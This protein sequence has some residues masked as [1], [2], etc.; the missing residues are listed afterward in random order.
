MQKRLKTSFTTFVLGLAT[1]PALVAQNRNSSFAEFKRQMMPKVGK[2]ITVVGSLASGKLGWV[3]T[4][5]KHGVYIYAVN[6]SDQ[7][8][9]ND[10]SRYLG[11]RV[12]VTGTLRYNPGSGSARDDVASVP[13]HFYFD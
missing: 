4:F 11:G 2:K 1:C 8:R 6:D 9:M 13:E 7:S 3:I 12:K 10:L 5:K